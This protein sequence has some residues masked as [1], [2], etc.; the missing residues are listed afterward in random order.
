MEAVSPSQK[1]VGRFEGVLIHPEERRVLYFVVKS[2]HLFRNRRYLLPVNASR[3]DSIRSAVCVDIEPDE[4]S[5]LPQAHPSAFPP[6]SDDDLIAA[7]L[8]PHAA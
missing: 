4:L 1:V 5:Q 2:H 3:I 6:F 8:S 7:L